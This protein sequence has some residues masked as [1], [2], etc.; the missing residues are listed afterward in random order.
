MIYELNKWSVVR[1]QPFKLGLITCD[2]ANKNEIIDTCNVSAFTLSV[3]L[4]NETFLEKSPV[5]SLAGSWSEPFF[6]LPFD[7]SGAETATFPLGAQ[8]VFL[9]VDYVIPELGAFRRIFRFG[10]AFSVSDPL[11]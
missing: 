11:L 9:T 6:L 3:K 8:T 5:S 7:F 1:G 4:E 2:P 10:G